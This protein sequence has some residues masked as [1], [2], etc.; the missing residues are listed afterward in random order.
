M[1]DP[2]PVQLIPTTMAAAAA[3]TPGLGP[4]Q[5]QNGPQNNNINNTNKNNSKNKQLVKDI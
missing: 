2:Y 1:C 5:L 3:A 4:L